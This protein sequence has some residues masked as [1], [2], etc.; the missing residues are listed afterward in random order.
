M[1]HFKILGASI[2]AFSMLLTPDFANAQLYREPGSVKNLPAIVESSFIMKFGEKKPTWHVR[3]RGDDE[4][5]QRYEGKFM[6]D[7]RRTSAV[8]NRDGVLEAMVVEVEPSELPKQAM[9]YMKKNYRD[10]V[11]TETTMVQ[12]NEKNGKTFEL[13]FYLNKVFKVAVFDENGKF[14]KLVDG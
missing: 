4:N 13:G 6:L 1:K 12:E 9:F 5:Q 10:N 11:I 14:L 2:F 8:Y 3:Y 7:N